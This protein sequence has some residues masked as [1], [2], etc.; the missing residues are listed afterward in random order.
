MRTLR[1]SLLAVPAIALLA[2]CQNP[3]SEPDVAATTP[4]ST[5]APM[6]GATSGS[7]SAVAGAR[8]IS[9][10]ELRTELADNTVTGVARNGQTFYSWFSPNGALH[11]QQA[12]LRDTGSWSVNSDGQLCTSLT[13]VNAGGQSCYAVYRN[14]NSL[15]FERTDGA[16]VGTFTFVPGNP[17]NL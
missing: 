6:A 13:H 2:G 11:F 17:Q 9:G 10:S 1:L 7:S 14:G 12:N 5:V 15:T 16:P 8:R 3:S 4:S